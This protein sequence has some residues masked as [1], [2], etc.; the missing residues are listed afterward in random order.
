MVDL[1]P[2]IP[3]SNFSN[4]STNFLVPKLQ[5]YLALDNLLPQG[6]PPSLFELRKVALGYFLPS[7]RDFPGFKNHASSNKGRIPPTWNH[8]NTNL[9]FKGRNH[10]GKLLLQLIHTC[11]FPV[12]PGIQIGQLILLAFQLAYIPLPEARLCRA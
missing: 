10:S 6:S 9:Q 2:N 7:L 12:Q 4:L 8:E 3:T 1:R 5:G 11:I